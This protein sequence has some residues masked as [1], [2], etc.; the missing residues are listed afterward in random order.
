MIELGSK[1]RDKVS[2]FTGI[3]SSRVQYLN[4]CVQYG[5]TAKVGKD[6]KVEVV[7]I[8]EGQLEVVDKGVSVKKKD[9]G[10][11]RFDAPKR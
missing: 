6:N 9:T 1:V 11:F 10:G 2:W 8:D 4:G 5:L 3:A 7:Y